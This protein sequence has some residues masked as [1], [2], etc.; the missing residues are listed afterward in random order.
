M[1]S[2]FERMGGTYRREGDYF[3]P[4][5]EISVAATDSPIGKYGRMRRRYLKEF[6]PASIPN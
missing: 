6:T 2:L 5:I 3:V 1:Q 4:N